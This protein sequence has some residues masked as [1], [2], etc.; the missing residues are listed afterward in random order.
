MKTNKPLNSVRLNSLINITALVSIHYFEFDK[1]F[2]FSGERHNYWEMVYVDSGNVYVTAEGKEHVLG[3]GEIIFHKP[4]EFHTISADKKTPSNVVVI[5]FVTNSKRMR[6]FEDKRTVLP[7]DLRHYIKTIISEG[8]KTFDLPF[9]NPHM[10]RLKFADNP[11][12]GGLQLIKAALEQLLIMMIRIEEE[13]LRKR[14]LVD[15]ENSENNI[16]D[17]IIRLLSGN[18]YGKITVNEICR[19]LSYSKTHISK[20]FNENMGCTIIEYYTIM[21][22]KEAKKLIREKCY[23]FTEISNMLC[24]SNPHYFSKVFKKITNMSPREYLQ[25]VTM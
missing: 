17:E 5:T 11:P 9:N 7:R 23:S 6:W 21:K 18:I 1:N 16:V 15:E 14:R 22:I 24:F 13:K 10:M 12:L 2:H 8:R 3:Q 25:S 20:T 4:D 19:N